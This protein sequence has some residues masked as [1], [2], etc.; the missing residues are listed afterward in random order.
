VL[1][2]SIHRARSPRTKARYFPRGS[3]AALLGVPAALVAAASIASFRPAATNIPLLVGFLLLA[4]VFFTLWFG[5][6]NVR[7]FRHA[8]RVVRGEHE[9]PDA[10]GELSHFQA[11]ATALSGTLGLGNVAGAALAVSAGGPGAIVWMIIAA[12]L[13]MSLKFASCTLSQLYRCQVLDGSICGGP[14]YYLD[15]GL[16]ELGRPRLG[17]ALGIISSVLT[18]GAALGGGDMLQSSQVVDALSAQ[19]DLGGG[20]RLIVGY[21]LAGAV[22]LTVFGG[23]ARIGRASARVVPA[24]CGLYLLG[25]S[26]LLLLNLPRLPSAIAAIVGGAMSGDALKGGILGIFAVGVQSATL[27]SQAGIGAESIAHAAAR[28]Q[29]PVREGL[30]GMLEPLL[31]TVV[32]SSLTGLIIVV[33]GAARPQA[34]MRGV[35]VMFSLFGATWPRLLLLLMVVLFAYTTMLAWCYYGERAWLYISSHL[36]GGQSVTIFR[37]AFVLCIVLGATRPF[38]SVIE[39]SERVAM[40]HAIP[41]ILG[42]LFLAPRLSSCLDDYWRRFGSR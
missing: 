13:G 33:S 29:E 23:I 27:S 7:G 30:V 37:Y 3:G 35:E 20:L 2:T 36:G 25:A 38:A 12:F 17:K 40:L 24:M 16:S 9:E 15:L 18:I 14:M 8:I 6:I 26:I 28:T 39:F 10:P 4:G 41:N 1:F 32:V 31:S 42:C 19:F 5:F 21:A 11:L 22:A 34:G